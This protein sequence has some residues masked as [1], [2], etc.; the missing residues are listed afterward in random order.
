MTDTSGLT[1]NGTFI[2]TNSTQYI[3][4][5]TEQTPPRNRTYQS[6]L[7]VQSVPTSRTQGEITV[8]IAPRAIPDRR[9]NSSTK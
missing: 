3:E 8:R 5:K 7:K 6:P 4:A 2:E 1:N 9:S